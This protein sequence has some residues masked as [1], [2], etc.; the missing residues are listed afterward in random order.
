MRKPSE[1]ID[2][3]VMMGKLGITSCE[4]DKLAFLEI[5]NALN[6][7]PAMQG[8]LRKNPELCGIRITIKE[9]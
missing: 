4:I 5:K 9:G 2:C 3:F 6:H 1:V 8:E 7:H